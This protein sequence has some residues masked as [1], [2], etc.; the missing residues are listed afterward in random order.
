MATKG[1]SRAAPATLGDVLT[2][3][4]GREDL[5][6]QRRHD[7]CSAVR[8]IAALLGRRPEEIAVDVEAL[9][10]Q[11]ALFTP[12]AARMSPR[13]WR[14]VR[15]LFT[16]ALTLTGVPMIRRRQKASWSPA[17]RHL[18][19]RVPDTYDRARLS[20]LA[21]YCS[22]QNIQPD[23]VGHEV[24]ANFA[25][26]LLENSLI[27]RPK[28]VHREACLA[29]NRA[30]AS[31][32]DWPA[33]Q[34]DVPNR[35]RDYALPVATYP[36]TLGEDL[37]AYLAHLAGAD[38]F[39]ETCRQPASPVTI[40]Y[41][42]QRIRLLATA[43]VH[44]GREP[45]SITGLPDLVEPEA[46]KAILTFFWTR[47]GKRKSGQLRQL[48]SLLVNIAKHWVRVPDAQLARL[49]AMR[50]QVDPGRTGMTMRNR[51]RLRQFDERE[52]LARLIDMPAAILRELPRDAV[53]RY[54]QAVRVQ[55]ALA[56]AILLV[57]PMRVENLAGLRLDRHLVQTRPGS[58][59]HLVIPAHEVKN[60]V[61]LEFSMPAHVCTII[62]VYLRRCRP[63]LMRAPSPFLF[64]S[65]SGAAK[66]PA[67]LAAQVTRAIARQTGLEINVHLFRHLSAM[68]FVRAFP[69]EYET[70]RLLLGHRSLT[71]TVNAYCGIE[72]ADALRRYDD[73]IDQYRRN[74]RGG[75][76]A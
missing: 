8:R 28:Q 57:A 18:L 7:L 66:S 63:L 9:R 26:Q 76:A 17:W 22:I 50:K 1:P 43:L 35:R 61:P 39:G 40:K 69:G 4:P 68:L 23:Q 65:H 13:R 16:A 37:E 64:P 59:R 46:A 14:N 27:E 71:T 45:A 30:G 70:V 34:L 6:R 55:S 74:E 20:R 38:L 56:V 52:N 21:A 24:V 12:A 67:Q 60:D 49:R 62:D 51:A 44:A 25:R 10:R 48:A 31:I 73:L 53:P 3:L 58:T 72:Q 47:N 2:A 54:E 42:R 41:T 15:S 32:P 5:A 36:A 75:R 29:W 33:I 11:V 19:E